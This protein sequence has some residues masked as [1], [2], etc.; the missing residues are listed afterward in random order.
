VFDAAARKIPIGIWIGT[1]DQFFPLESVRA[2]A[3]ALESRGFPVTLTEIPGHKHDYIH[4]EPD[5][6]LAI[7]AFLSAQ[8][9]PDE[10]RFRRYA[11]PR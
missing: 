11:D 6:D 10:P 7:W 9:L 3:R 8:K 5:L 4:Y 1:K 2:T